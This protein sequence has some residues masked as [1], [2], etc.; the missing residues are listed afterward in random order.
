MPTCNPNWM[1]QAK[2]KVHFEGILDDNINSKTRKMGRYTMH[3]S[4]HRVVQQV[5]GNLADRNAKVCYTNY[6][7]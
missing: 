5:G 4:E 7:Y 1:L 3:E 6:K 2:P